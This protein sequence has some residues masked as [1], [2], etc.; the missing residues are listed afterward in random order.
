M[1]RL[2]YLTFRMNLVE[3]HLV[4]LDLIALFGGDS[5]KIELDEV[6]HQ[7][8]RVSKPPIKCVESTAEIDYLAFFAR[9]LLL[10]MICFRGRWTVGKI[11]V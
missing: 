7:V 2:H 8:T 5:G 4:P 9:F 11:I 1:I 10:M 3:Q 6:L